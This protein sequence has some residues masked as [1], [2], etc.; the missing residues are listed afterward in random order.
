MEKVYWTMRNGN[1]ISVDD[2]DITH[3]R[4]TLKMIIRNSEK[5]IETIKTA[6]APARERFD[7]RGE[8]AREQIENEMLNELMGDDLDEWYGC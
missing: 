5:A 7:V 3:L 8:I 4:N 6:S 2:M 1:K